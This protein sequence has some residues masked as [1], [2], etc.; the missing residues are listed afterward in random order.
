MVSFIMSGFLK[1]HAHPQVDRQSLRAVEPS[2]L[3]TEYEVRST[4]LS[5]Y[6]AP[7]QVSAGQVGARQVL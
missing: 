2:T 1:A 5:E 6:G 7:G 4:E 3:H